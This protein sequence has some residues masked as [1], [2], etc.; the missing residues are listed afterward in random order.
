MYV[1]D[2]SNYNSQLIIV[3]N[4]NISSIIDSSNI[5]ATF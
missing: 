4:D 3:S 2:N 1:N 5:I